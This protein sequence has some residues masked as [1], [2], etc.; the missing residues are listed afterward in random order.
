MRL[1]DHNNAP[2]KL[3]YIFTVVTA[4]RMTTATLSASFD[5]G[6]NWRPVPIVRAHNGWLAGMSNPANGGVSLRFAAADA[7]GNTVS[8][9]I[10]NAYLVS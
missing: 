2:A 4:T 8:Q 3:P 10:T 9:T 5:S 1:D 6:A 7:A